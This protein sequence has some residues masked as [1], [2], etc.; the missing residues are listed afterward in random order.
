MEMHDDVIVCAP[1]LLMAT[2]CIKYNIEMDAVVEELRKRHPDIP[3]KEWR[4]WAD[5]LKAKARDELL[6]KLS[7]M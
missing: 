7:H 3:E 6:W 1:A 2:V 5:E 4:A